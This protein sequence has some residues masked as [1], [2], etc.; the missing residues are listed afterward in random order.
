M[1]LKFKCTNDSCRLKNAH[2]YRLDLPSEL[3]MD[4]K[5]VAV[6]YCPKCKS[7]LKKMR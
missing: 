6:M 3:V 2:Q 1:K 5:N 4:E 7:Q